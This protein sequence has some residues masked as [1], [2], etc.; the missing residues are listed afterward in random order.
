M[1]AVI[2]AERDEVRAEAVRLLELF[3]ISLVQRRI[4]RRRIVV[5]RHHADHLVAHRVE[6]VI[7]GK[8]AGTDNLDSGAGK[9]SLGELL[10]KN[11]GLCSGKIDESSIRVEIA[12]ALQKRGEIRIG[13]R[14]S[15]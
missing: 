15:D 10:G 4:M 14:N 3:D 13:E 12:N 7:V 11:A 5:R 8:V 1:H 9:T 6:L 2:A